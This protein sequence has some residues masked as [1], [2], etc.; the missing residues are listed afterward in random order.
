MPEL[1]KLKLGL[2]WFKNPDHTPF[3]IAQEFG[4]FTAAGLD[5]ELIE[6]DAHMDAIEAINGGVWDLAITEPLHLIEDRSQ[7]CEAAKFSLPCASLS[8]SLLPSPLFHFKGHK[9]VGFCRFLHTN[10]GVMY[11]KNKGPR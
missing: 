3:F 7:G 1:Q 9:A 4:W 6:P 10:G 8:S 11:W 5:V 2:E